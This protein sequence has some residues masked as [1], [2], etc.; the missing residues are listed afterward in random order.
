MAVALHASAA[1]LDIT[2]QVAYSSLSNAQRGNTAQHE[3]Q[4]HSYVRMEL[5][6]MT[7]RVDL[8]ARNNVDNVSRLITVSL[9]SHVMFVPLKI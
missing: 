2:A 8:K 9:V 4:S 6:H 5:L 7:T 1:Q 3:R